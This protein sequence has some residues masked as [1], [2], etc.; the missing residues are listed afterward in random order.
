VLYVGFPTG[1]LRLG[2]I[3]ASGLSVL[4]SGA[5]VSI[6]IAGQR[7]RGRLM[8]LSEPLMHTC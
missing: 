2:A 8:L 5:T 1:G 3:V 7:F 6:E 4:V